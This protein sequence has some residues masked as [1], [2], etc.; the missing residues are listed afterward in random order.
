MTVSMTENRTAPTR[1]QINTRQAIAGALLMG[2][3]GLL[4]VAGA[5]IAASSFALAF[6]RH[7]KQLDVPASAYARQNWTRMKSATAAGVGAWRD[8]QAAAQAS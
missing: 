2:A 5:A 6:R 3:G 4:G 8:A 7:L 1:F